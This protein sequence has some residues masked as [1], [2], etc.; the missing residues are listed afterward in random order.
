VTVETR[1]LREYWDADAATYVHT[2]AISSAA[3]RAAWRA[4][5]TRLLPAPPA[6]VL[7]AGAGTGELSVLLAELGHRVTALDFSPEM[8]AQLREQAERRGLDI[9]A[10]TAEA[11]E[12]P[13]G[14][15]D[16]VT[17]RL[18]LWMAEDRVSVLASWRD[19]APHGRLAVFE[20]IWGGAD[21]AQEYKAK[22]RKALA[23]L[24]GEPPH[25]HASGDPSIERLFSRSARPGEICEAVS[26]AGWPAVRLERLRDV[27]W[28]EASAL[29]PAARLLGTTPWYAVA[30]G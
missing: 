9:T 16:A 19:V 10:V 8:L 30:A 1:A 17:A 5:L 6:R 21:P 23:R 18:L 20:G 12:P 26:S 28:A 15:F 13:E 14:P 4:T 3:T 29:S 27:E 25:H 11:H 22:A 24:R 7:D 2:H